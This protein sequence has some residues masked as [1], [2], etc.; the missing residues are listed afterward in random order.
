M[1][2]LARPSASGGRRTVSRF[3]SLLA[4]IFFNQLRIINY[5]LRIECCIGSPCYMLHLKTLPGQNSCFFGSVLS[6]VTYLKHQKFLPRPR[7]FSNS[8]CHA[9]CPLDVS[10]PHRS[11]NR[12]CG[13]GSDKIGV[14][15]VE[16]QMIVQHLLAF[17]EAETFSDQF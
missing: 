16:I 4:P 1:E 10:D 11:F 3:F 15:L 2:L 14:A 17:R 9:W 7:M 6:F 13:M 8:L 5:E 12:Q